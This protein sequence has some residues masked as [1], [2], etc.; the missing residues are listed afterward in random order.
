M[1]N[2]ELGV[3]NFSF[4]TVRIDE[5][6]SMSL[7]TTKSCA[8][9]FVNKAIILYYSSSLLPH[10]INDVLQIRVIRVRLREKIPYG[11]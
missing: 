5:N 1:K 10:R 8:Q 11:V 7:N 2:F 9:N 6:P 4:V 3:T